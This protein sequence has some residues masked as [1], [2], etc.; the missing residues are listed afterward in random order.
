M[1]FQFQ[2]NLQYTLVVESISQDLINSKK[3]IQFRSNDTK[4]EVLLSNNSLTRKFL[5]MIH[6]I[7]FQFISICIRLKMSLDIQII[8]NCFIAIVLFSNGTLQ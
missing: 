5:I 3:I 4:I 1:N 8:Q 2:K 6:C 7:N